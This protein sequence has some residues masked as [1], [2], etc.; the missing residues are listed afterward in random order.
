MSAELRLL[1]LSSLLSNV[2]AGF[3]TPGGPVS[4]TAQGLLASSQSGIIAEQQRLAREEAEKAARGTQGGSIGALLLSA[5]GGGFFGQAGAALGGAVGQAVGTELGGGDANLQDALVSGGVAGVSAFGQEG[6]SNVFRG[7]GRETPF[8]AGQAAG[9][10]GRIPQR[11]NLRSRVGAGFR[12]AARF[13]Q[14]Q[15]NNF[16]NEGAGISVTANPQT[17]GFTISGIRG[18]GGF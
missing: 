11:Q 14:A 5:L 15:E 9:P 7:G 17:G 4:R 8:V 18:F 2:G 10:R 3:S 6:V 12:G 16:G 13:L 1:Q